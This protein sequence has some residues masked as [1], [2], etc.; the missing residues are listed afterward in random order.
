[1][2]DGN[3]HCHIDNLSRRH[4]KNGHRI[5]VA[6]AAY[7]SGQR[8]WS[9]IEQRFVEFGMREDVVFSEILLPEGAPA[10]ARNR[11]ALWNRVDGSA[12]RIDA[13]LA[14]TIVAAIARDIPPAGRVA[15]LRAFAAPLV[16]LGCVAD[17][18]IHEDGTDHNPHIH[19]LLTT[20]RL[21]AD[22]FGDK[23]TALEQRSFVKQVRERWA[24][25]SNRF[26]EQAGSALRVDHRSYRARGIEAEPTVHR[27]PN[28]LERRE[29]REH[30]RRVR[31]ER[32]MPKPTF[33]EQ[34]E[35]PLLSAR[36]TWPPE[37]EASPDMTGRERDEHHRYW[38][39]RKLDRLEE[40][41]QS[42]PDGPWYRQ[43][44][45]RART[46]AAGAEDSPPREWDRRIGDGEED[47]TP[48][49]DYDYEAMVRKRALAMSRTREEDEVLQSVREQPAEVRRFVHDFVLHGRMQTI[50]DQDLAKRLEQ[51]QPDI[52]TKLELLRPSYPDW[53]HEL[54]V[55]GPDRELLT[56]RELDRARDDMLAEYQREE[57]RREEWER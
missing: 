24:K 34:R 8:L 16:A 35:Y 44:L 52:R 45:E 41:H 23:L 9:E 13:R 22:G 54:P 6:S 28:E 12:L 17:V 42:E 27:G 38:Q 57:P 4:G 14:K 21:T 49:P 36:E 11:A 40:H 15:L 37:P 20:R 48:P 55:P 3:I 1:M 30:A 7:V 51:V 18:A 50:R 53:D 26:L 46:A 2:Q 33:A 43:A 5:A 56:E 47:H 32:K 29:K 31:E 25:L 19:L 39:D 10:W